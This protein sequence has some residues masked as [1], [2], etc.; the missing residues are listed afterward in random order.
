MNRKIAMSL[1]SVVGALTL[2]GGAA[3]AAFTTTASATTNTFSSTTPS[4]QLSVDGA[5]FG[6]PVPGVTVNGLIPGEP[7]LL[8][9]LQYITVI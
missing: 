9:I 2:M 6:N 7:R 5:P 1:L 3:F 4:L 8:I